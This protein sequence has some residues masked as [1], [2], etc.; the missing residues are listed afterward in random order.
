V[1]KLVG[2]LVW[3]VLLEEFAAVWNAA[4]S[5]EEAAEV[6]RGLAGPAPCWAVRARAEELRRSG[7][8]LKRLHSLR[9]VKAS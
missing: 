7:L 5:V 6:I 3:D 2:L 4:A 8:P 9:R 1:G